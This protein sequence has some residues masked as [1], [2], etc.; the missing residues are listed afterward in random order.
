[1]FAN[2]ND[3]AREATSSGNGCPALGSARFRAGGELGPRAVMAAPRIRVRSRR[4]LYAHRGASSLSKIPRAS[5]E[6]FV[7]SYGKVADTS[8]SVNAQRE[9]AFLSGSEPPSSELERRALLGLAF[10]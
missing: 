6:V 7:D 4:V 10:G 8:G 3:W 1:M 5:C 2:G 9:G